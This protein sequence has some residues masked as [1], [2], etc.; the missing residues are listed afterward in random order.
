MVTLQS[1]IMESLGNGIL[2]SSASRCSIWTQ[3]YRIIKE[4]NWDFRRSPWTYELHDYHDPLVCRKGAQL[5]FTELAINRVLYYLDVRKQSCLY[6]LP[7]AIPDAKD[8]SMDRLD[9]AIKES[10]HL[11]QLFSNTKNIGYKQ[12]GKCSLYIRGAKSDNVLKSIPVSFIVFDEFD[13]MDPDKI[14]LAIERMSGQ[15]VKSYLKLSTPT[16]PGRGI[17]KE[18][19]EG[20]KEEY[21][22]DCPSCS[23]LIKLSWP[24]SVVI[25]AESRIDPRIED[26]YYQCTECKNKLPHAAKKD[27]L[28]PKGMGGSGQFV[29]SVNVAA[30]RSVHVS[31]LYSLTMTP[32]EIADSF[33]LSQVRPESEREFYKSKLGVPYVPKGGQISDQDIDNAI[34]GTYATQDVIAKRQAR[35]RTM[36]VDVGRFFHIV[37]V[38]W[39][40]DGKFS[41]ELNL[42]AVAKVLTAVKT[43]SPQQVNKYFREYNC[44]SMVIDAQPERRVSQRIIER[45]TGRAYMCFYANN[46]RGNDL[47]FKHENS[48]VSADR[49]A[50]M[51]TAL[52]RFFSKRILLPMDINEEY[53]EHLK[54]PIRVIELDSNNN[55]IAKYVS[56]TNEDHYAHAQT[57]ADIALPIAA[58]L[59]S[60]VPITGLL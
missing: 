21:Y 31:Q 59:R 39:I 30:H 3:L 20:T 44:D 4:K 52:S 57:Y 13:E 56:K 32:R 28:L 33:F 41:R 10:N 22:F 14:P 16:L 55:P 9:V 24:E 18:Y 1:E 45:Y 25:T 43:E 53:R 12:A 51:D 2:R 34:Q 7:A 26:T 60:N 58:S 50:W 8:F 37:I 38:E 47:A 40:I 11:T 27:F 35:I 17:D 46:V 48:I 5:A 19:Q 49:T 6:L 29:K 36:G 54:Q 15:D 42:V 23:R